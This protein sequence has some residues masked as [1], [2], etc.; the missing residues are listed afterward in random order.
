MSRLS[1]NIHG[2]NLADRAATLAHL[3]RLKPAWTLVMDN[4]DL[5]R[6]VKARVGVGQVI[7]R[8]WPDDGL[9]TWQDADTW[10]QETKARIGSS[11]LWAYAGNEP[12]FS[13]YIVRQTARAL[14]VESHRVQAARARIQNAD[15]ALA[16]FKRGLMAFYLWLFGWLLVTAEAAAVKSS[17]RWAIEVIGAARRHGLKVVVLNLSSG[18]PQPD[19]WRQPLALELLRALDSNRDIAVLGLHEYACGVIT[20][21]F[22][23]GWP[24]LILQKDWPPDVRSLTMWHCGRYMF[25][26]RACE[27]AGIRP[28]R[29][30]ITEFGFDDM[31]DVKA[32]AE[33]LPRTP[34]Y[35]SIRGWKSLV[36]AWKAW[37]P[38]W[39][40]ED[41]LY[42]SIDYSERVTYWHPAVEGLLWFCEGAS[43]PV[44]D[45]FNIE[46][47]TGLKTRLEERMTPVTTIP[48]PGRW[49]VFPPLGSL[50][51][52]ADAGTDKPAVG[53]LV[54]GDVVQVTAE[55]KTATG[56]TWLKVTTAAG[57]TGWVALVANLRFETVSPPPVVTAEEMRALAADL[58]SQ[59]ARLDA[60]A[61]QFD[62]IAD[63]L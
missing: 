11:D 46:R 10:A 3:A 33:M 45:Q 61:E 57:I 5:A 50:N 19:D 23:G 59:A 31:S 41:V 55:T 51:V 62:T 48:A 16:R 63:R 35:G 54:S 18:T 32:W 36:E 25:L 49:Q 60:L 42:Q 30:V 20:S 14:R 53:T 28:P 37:Y 17:V 56:Y 47:Q 38:A 24:T 13:A 1:Y 4:L 21:G 7:F 39:T 12:G 43:S 40:A 26:I 52:R 15:G 9:H 6:E 2:H 29:I 44:W 22:I 27:A 58:R 8:A 34:G